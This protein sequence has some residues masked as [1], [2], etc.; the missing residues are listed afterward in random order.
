MRPSRRKR[1]VLLGAIAGLLVAPVAFAGTAPTEIK[2]GAP[3]QNVF[4]PANP[5]AKDVAQGATFHWSRGAGNALPHNVAQDDGLFSSGSPTSGPINFSRRASAGTFP[6]HC[7]FHFGMTGTIRARPSLTGTSI[8]TI[9]LQWA[10]SDTNTGKAFDVH[11]RV[12]G[13]DW[14]KWRND[15]EKL[16]GTFG[17]N[18]KPI[19]VETGET[20]S[21]RARSEK[22]VSQP[23]KRSGWSPIVSYTTH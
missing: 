21:F 4:V 13:G 14:K 23:G 19:H 1:L 22:S 3:A 11:Y 17:R 20:Y 16:Q 5:P 2:V 15:T 10:R 12:A 6:Y 9:I 8:P 7:D 18:D